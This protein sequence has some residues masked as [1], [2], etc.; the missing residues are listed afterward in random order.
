M[1]SAEAGVDN[2]PRHKFDLAWLRGFAV[3]RSLFA[4]TD[5]ES[6]IRLL[7]F[8]QVDPIRA[9]ARAQDLILRHRVID[10]RDGDIDRRYREL[11]LAE[12]YVHVYGILPRESQRLLH[13][14][15]GEHVFR[16][17][18]EHPDLAP[19]VRA[20][21]DKH[22][23]THPRDLHRA[24]GQTAMINGWGGR[25]A[26][27][28]RSLE[29]LHYRGMLH[30]SH[31]MQGIRIYDIAAARERS[32]APL[33]RGVGIIKLLLRLYAPLTEAS[34]RTLATS[35]DT[36]SLPVALRGPAIDRVLRGNSVAHGRVDGVRQFW[37][38]GDDVH[39]GADGAVRFLT[40]FDP[41]VWDRKRFEQF[42]HWDYRFE[43]YTPPTKRRFGY[44]ALPLLYRDSVIGWVNVKR[45]RDTLD[46]EIGFVAKRPR[47]ANFRRELDAEIARFATFLGGIPNA[48]GV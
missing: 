47:E 21:I 3:R 31:R 23:A 27:T 2:V 39:T 22:G 4:P 12:D 32:L 11:P 9:P 15:A 42:W 36:G 24:L 6:A 38:A 48:N 41:I 13:P 14:R 45:R 10:Y 37:P 8:V 28:T 30:V 34:L 16:V 5:L 20:H 40:P 29:M 35:V 1:S 25:S 43:A 46:F 17:E 19:K 7:G 18:R 44:Y 26:A 33:T